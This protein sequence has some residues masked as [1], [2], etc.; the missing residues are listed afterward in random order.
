MSW[1]DAL[2]SELWLKP[3]EYLG[4]KIVFR[5]LWSGERLQFI[6]SFVC[7]SDGYYLLEDGTVATNNLNCRRCA[8]QPNDILL[9]ALVH[10]G[11]IPE[12]TR[13]SI[14]QNER[15]RERR[16]EANRRKEEATSFASKAKDLG[17][18]LNGAQLKKLELATEEADAG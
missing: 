12:S 13:V 10:F 16:Q 5:P 6:D 15:E 1:L 17:I 8:D 9:R 11:I 3:V 7:A 14:W 18:E 2:E 4:A